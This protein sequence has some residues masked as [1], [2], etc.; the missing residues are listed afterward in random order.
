MRVRR[1]TIAMTFA[2]AAAV[3]GITSLAWACTYTPRIFALTPEIGP[4]ASEVTMTGQGLAP[5]GVVEIRWNSASGPKIAET[6]ADPSGN[7]STV[8]KVPDVPP[9]VYSLV[10]STPD[11]KGVA[12]AAFELTGDS[13]FSSAPHAAPLTPNRE[14]ATPPWIGRPDEFRPPSSGSPALA[15]G[16]GLLGFGLVVLF[17]GTAVLS[18]RRR[19]AHEPLD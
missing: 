11:G 14:N 16:A 19:R 10:A 2:A 4:R 3:V 18:L 13:P 7:F 9:G 5:Q 15:L 17:A 1:G 6:V 8:T 12:R